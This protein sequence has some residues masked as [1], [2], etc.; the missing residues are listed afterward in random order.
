[1]RAPSIDQRWQPAATAAV[2]TLAVAAIAFP[3]LFYPFGRDQGIH[4]YIAKLAGDGLVVYR[5]IFNVKP[6]MTTVVH[7]LSQLLFGETMYAIRLMDAVIIA[8]TGILL[9]LL[10]A[11]HLRSSWL[12]IVAAVAYAASHFSNGYW[13]TAQTDGWCGLFMTASVFAYSRALDA[14]T[15]RRRLWLLAAAGVAVGLSFWT[16]YTS[17]VV[18]IVFPAVHM[19]MGYG[20]RRILADG[21]AVAAGLIACIGLGIAVLA[22]QGALYPFLDIQ[23]FMRSY[24]SHGPSLLHAFLAPFFA[25]VGAKM[26][27]AFAMLGLYAAYRSISNRRHVPECAGM[28]AWLAAGTA[29]GLLQGKMFLYHMLPMQPPLAVAAAV[30]VGALAQ[31]LAGRTKRTVVVPVALVTCALIVA[32]SEIPRKYRE[33][34]PVLRGEMTLRAFYDDPAFNHGDFMTTHNLALVDYLKEKTLPCDSAFLWGYEPGVYFLSGRPL[35][36]RFV[37]NFPMFTAYYRQSYRDEFMAGLK[38]TPPSVFIVEHEDRTPH[39]SVHNNDSAEVFEQFP[40]LKAFI[41]ANYALRDRVTRFDVYFREDIVPGVA[42]A[43]PAR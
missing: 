20:A 9:Q 40:A 34:L 35:V 17:A 15:A 4:A 41:A 31:W 28:L 6:P 42:R 3:S 30:G 2:V 33:I 36:T 26:V 43:C 16:K 13:F 8:V 21:A 7:W 23:D 18:V 38:A 39:V 10:A 29:S 11:R 19:A 27:P 5:D 22:A 32:F 25:L 37:F 14:P 24:I 1:M 12:G